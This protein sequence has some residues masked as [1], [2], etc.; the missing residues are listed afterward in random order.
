MSF[1]SPDDAR[2]LQQLRAR[3]LLVG[4]QDARDDG[5]AQLEERLRAPL[6][7]LRPPAPQP[8]RVLPLPRALACTRPAELKSPCPGAVNI[9]ARKVIA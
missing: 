4:P 9:A 5:V 2:V 6:L 3:A 1:S 7:G 8:P